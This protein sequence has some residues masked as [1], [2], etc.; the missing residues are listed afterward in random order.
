MTDSGR[1]RGRGLDLL[2]AL[3]LQAE[4][5]SSSSKSDS[6]EPGTSLSQNVAPSTVNI[7]FKI[8][9]IHC[10]VKFLQELHNKLKLDDKN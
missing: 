6:S 5:S 8:L 9:T 7:Y 4:S 3:K 1:G 2:K 10:I